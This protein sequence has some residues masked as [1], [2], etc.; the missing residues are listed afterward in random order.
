MLGRLEYQKGNFD[1]A[2]QVF[3]GIDVA[4]LRPRLVKAMAERTRQRKVRSKVEILP[5]NLMSWH[6]V[7]LLLEAVFLKSKSL[8]ELGRLEG[9]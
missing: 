4:A 9:I 5:A 6:S 3:Q 1:A 2:L 7:S 8:E